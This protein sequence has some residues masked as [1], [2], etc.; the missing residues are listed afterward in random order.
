MAGMGDWETLL[1]HLDSM[2]DNVREYARYWY[3]RG[4]ANKHLENSGQCLEDLERAAWMESYNIQYVIDAGLACTELGA[5]GRSEQHWRRV[6]KL[7][8]RNREAL[9]YLAQS[10]EAHHDRATAISL[11]REFL[12]YHTDFQNAQEILL[13]LDAN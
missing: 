4:M 3:L 5:Y 1:S 9:L 13:K 2:N 12:T 8:P 11:L 6:L 7:S 10:R